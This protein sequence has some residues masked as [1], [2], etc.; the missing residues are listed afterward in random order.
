MAFLL[1]DS[2]QD[3]LQ[4]L[5]DQE[6]KAA[7]LAAF[8]LQMNPASPGLQCHRLDGIKDTHFWSA[9]AN[10][11]IRLIFHRIESSLLLCYVDHHDRAYAWAERRKI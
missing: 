8:E 4:K 7:K 1:A 6:Q 5:N 2:F 9:R 11:D 3:S 10:R